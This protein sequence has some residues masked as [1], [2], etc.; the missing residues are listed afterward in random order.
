MLIMFILYYA[1]IIILGVAFQITFFK[2]NYPLTYIG[3]FFVWGNTCIAFSVFL[4]SFLRNPSEAL[5][6]GID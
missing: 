2:E 3:L 4:S 1:I 6:V 5:M